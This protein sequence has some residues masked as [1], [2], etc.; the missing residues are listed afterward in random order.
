MLIFPEFLILL[1]HISALVYCAD[2][3]QDKSDEI[4]SADVL[5]PNE[6]SLFETPDLSLTS[7]VSQDQVLPEWNLPDDILANA[8]FN[9]PLPPVSTES[10]A[11]DSQ[12]P[13]RVRARKEACTVEDSAS[14]PRPAPFIPIEVQP[15]LDLTAK[16]L[17]PVCATQN[18][19]GQGMNL[20]CSSGDP[21]DVEPVWGVPFH[22][23]LSRCSLSKLTLF[24][25]SVCF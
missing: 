15:F 19:F 13:G 8:N 16:K 22:Y 7:V 21:K 2:L 23:H 18:I 3:F 12:L 10:C 4:D 6:E 20:V 17:L 25:G 1:I 9:P 24:K 5:E 11:I 14:Y